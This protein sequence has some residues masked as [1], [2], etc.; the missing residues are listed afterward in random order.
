LCALKKIRGELYKLKGGGHSAFF[1]DCEVS[2]WDPEECTKKCGGGEQK[3]T[4]NVLAQPKGGTKCLPL[5]AMGS[6]NN[7]PCPV[8]CKL[9]QWGGWSKCSAKCGGGV[10]QRVRDVKRAMMY[11]GKPCGQTSQAKPCNVEA[12]EKDCELGEWTKWTS[13]SK[14]CDGGSK[15]RQKFITEPAEG[16]GTC[17]GT[18][19]KRRL[20]YKGCNRVRCK[21]PEGRKTITCNTTMD[22]ILMIDQCPKNGEKA[23]KAQIEA[24]STLVDAF[25]GDGITAVPNFAIIQYCG[26]RT[27]SGVSKCAGKSTEKVD[28]E[29]TCR[30]KVVQHFDE[31][32]KKT[33]NTLN[34]LSFA[35]GTKLVA[36]ALLTAKAELSLGRKTAQSAVIVFTDGQPLSFRKTKLASRSL[37]KKTRLHW[38][39]TTKFSPLKDIKKWA[40][41]R[42]QENIVKV[43]K[44]EKLAKPVTVTHVL[45]NICP[46]KFPKLK[47]KRRRPPL[48]LGQK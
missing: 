18:W 27:W 43:S 19:S 28:I 32:L 15:K 10:T 29:K 45:A 14:N 7:F 1:Q 11:N 35:K 33:K 26:P 24:A 37:R 13:C 36:L 44:Y 38:V 39:V 5:A 4:R 41:R 47:T 30:T 9:H 21:I 12:C 16:E 40:S 42:W 2:K 46:K 34:G 20:Q 31:D 8:D 17:P 22:V 48:M 3:L 25:G 6:C 23:F